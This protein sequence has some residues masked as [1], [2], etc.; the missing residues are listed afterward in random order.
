M[1]VRSEYCRERR[2]LEQSSWS[3]V[4][5]LSVLTEQLMM[6]IGKDH[7]QFMAAKARCENMKR[8][9]LESHDRLRTHRAAHGC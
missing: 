2:E 9:I 6:L 3:L 7:T 8:E 4:G 5:K 1:D